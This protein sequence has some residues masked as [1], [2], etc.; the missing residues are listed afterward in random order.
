MIQKC[1]HT[2]AAIL[3]LTLF[4][5]FAGS[6]FGQS[7]VGTTAASF[8]GISV[9]PRATALGGAFAAVADDATS[10]YYNPAGIARAG[11]SQ[12]V[13]SYTSLLVDTDFSWIGLMFN[14]DGANAIG[15]SLTQLNYGEEEVTTVLDPEGTGEKWGASDISIALS[16]AR[17]L[18]DRFSIG[19]NAKFIQEKL[20]NESASAFAFDVGLLYITELH[21]MRL[22]MSITNFGTDMRLD[23]KDLLKRVDLDPEAIGHNDN[24]VS[25]LKTDDWPLPLFF[26]VGLAMDVLKQENLRLTTAI[27]A[28]RPSDNSEV[29]N[30]GAEMEL[31]R[32]L[33]LRGGYK[34][35]FREDSEE[36]L[37]LGMGLNF[38][39]G[40]GFSWAFDYTFADFGLLEDINMFSLGVTF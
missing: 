23:G 31:Y 30:V 17:S 15:L 10:L 33:F 7:K 27:D 20:W 39:T 9:G 8:L 26:R 18:T 16:Y 13:F 11:R 29:L 2:A 32:L 40:P 35:L 28:L 25:R 12:F 36:G 5:A 19:G 4:V 21:D 1:A 34:S 24:I 37:T 6:A 3:L 22:G 38:S 14:L